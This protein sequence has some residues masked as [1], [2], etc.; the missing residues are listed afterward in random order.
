M[1][2]GDSAGRIR[3]EAE[4]CWEKNVLITFSSRL[5]GLHTFLTFLMHLGCLCLFS[6]LT[7]E[8]PGIQSFL[9]LLVSHLLLSDPSSLKVLN[10]VGGV[11]GGG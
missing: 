3:L 4:Y 1:M 6:S 11:G 10:R 7:V 9:S 8:C 2:P 5:P